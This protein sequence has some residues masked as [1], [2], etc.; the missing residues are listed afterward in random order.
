MVLISFPDREPPRG[1]FSTSSDKDTVPTFE[2]SSQLTE[3]VWVVT[4]K[5]DPRREQYLATPSI[6]WSVQSDGT[7]DPT[8]YDEGILALGRLLQN[9]RDF[10]TLRQILNHENL[11]SMAGIMSY[12]LFNK[13]QTPDNTV[14]NNV[15]LLVYDFLDAGNLSTLFLSNQCESSA[16]YLPESLCWHVLRSLTRAVTYLHDGKR[17]SYHKKLPGE[18]ATRDWVSVGADWFPILHRRIEPKNVWFQH[19]RGIET[20]GQCKLG[21]LSTAA[22]TGHVI[23]AQSEQSHSMALAVRTG[24]IE[25]DKARLALNK[26]P[27]EVEDCDRP[28][29]LKDEMWSIGVTVFTMMTGKAPT[30]GCDKCGCSHVVHCSKAGCLE[31]KA[32]GKGCNC[33]LGGC[34]HIPDGDCDEPISRWPACPPQHHCSEPVINIHSYLVRA[35]YTKTLRDIIKDLLQYDPQQR[36]KPLLKAVNFAE[37]VEKEYLLW[38]GETEEGRDYV[39]LEDDMDKRLQHAEG[40]RA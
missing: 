35:R 32:A 17:L 11:I 28:Y 15:Q 34:E 2:L 10:H 30:Y 21:D 39:D 40:K 7:I 16:F 5:G 25:L 26:N 19:S 12:Q 22:V 29:T 1:L 13:S 27:A 38:K 14:K 31:K 37:V 23:D 3:K 4:R 36:G 9:Q 8:K 18:P 24:V 6:P 20:Y 33:I